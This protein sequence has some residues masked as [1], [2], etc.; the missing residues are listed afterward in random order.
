MS[1]HYF[2]VCF[3][4]DTYTNPLAPVMNNSD[5]RGLRILTI[6]ISCVFI[7]AWLLY[8][9]SNGGFHLWKDASDF[10]SSN[11]YCTWSSRLI[12]WNE[13]SKSHY[14]ACRSSSILFLSRMFEYVLWIHF[15]RFQFQ[16]KHTSVPH[17]SISFSKLDIVIHFDH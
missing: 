10:Q 3:P 4:I 11:L 8:D 15:Q 9:A 5:V 12:I 16:A 7:W 13:A 14:K 6:L 2:Y 17:G 1:F